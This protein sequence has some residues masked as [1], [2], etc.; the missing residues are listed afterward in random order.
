MSLE[1]GLISGTDSQRMLDTCLKVSQVAKQ[2]AKPL[3]AM[4]RTNDILR[5]FQPV[6]VSKI[7]IGVDLSILQESVDL[8]VVG[9]QEEL[10]GSLG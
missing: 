8:K 7:V 2:F 9:L 6:G 10:D 1:L 3:M 4:L 5:K